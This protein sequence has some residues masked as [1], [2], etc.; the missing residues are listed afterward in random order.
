MNGKKNKYLGYFDQQEEVTHKKIA[1][2][3]ILK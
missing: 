1:T 2:K 3:A